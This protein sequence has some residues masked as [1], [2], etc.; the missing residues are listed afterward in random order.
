MRLRITRVDGDEGTVLRIDGRLAAGCLDEFRKACEETRQR[1][2]LNLQGVLW[3]DDRAA[4]YVRSLIAGGAIVTDAS[5]YV[6]LR[7]NDKKDKEVEP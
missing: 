2:L 6:A 7:L 5:P 3:I 4:E 1:L